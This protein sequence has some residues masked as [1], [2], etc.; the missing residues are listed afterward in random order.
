M[1]KPLGPKPSGSPLPHTIWYTRCPVP[2]ASGIAIQKGWLKDAFAP[3]GIDVRSMRHAQDPK[4]RESHYTHTLDNSFRQGGNTP[5]LFARSEGKD[6]VLLGLHWIPQYQAIL[7]LPESGITKIHQ[8]K[9]RRLA[10]PRRVN[11]AID[12]WRATALQGYQ[13]ALRLDGLELSDVEL[14]DLPIEASYVDSDVEITESLTAAPRLSKYQTREMTAL[15]RG[16]V[17]AMFGYSVWGASIRSQISAT[18]IVNLSRHPSLKTQVNNGA[19]ET[20]TVS[21]ALLREHP[22]LV[23]RYVAQLVRAAAW[24]SE[25]ED[26]A[27]RAIA[28]ETGAAEYWLDEGCQP[29]VAHRLAFSLDEPLVEALE[30]RKNFLLEF[31]FFEHDF[32]IRAWMDPRPLQN[33]LKSLGGRV[34]SAGL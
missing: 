5:A 17:D 26:S 16:E 13:N 23:E 18:E 22:E 20:L 29:D 34:Q 14:V 2:T 27:R 8:L 31:G 24:A 21:G 4:T 30:M 6:T 32:N 7:T 11:D 1:N 25:N 3:D 28:I 19:P 12:F 9:G 15:L 33:A 10:L